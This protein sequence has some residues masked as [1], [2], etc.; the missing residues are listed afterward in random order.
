MLS[1]SLLILLL[2]I[3]F[4]PLQTI[5]QFVPLEAID[6]AFCLI[7]GFASVMWVE[8]LKLIRRNNK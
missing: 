4:T 5:F 1:I 6:L 2:S 7:A 3:Y 8:I